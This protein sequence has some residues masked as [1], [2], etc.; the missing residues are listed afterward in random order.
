MENLKEKVERVIGEALPGATTGL[1]DIPL[2]EKLSGFVIWEEF[3]G[4]SQRER[5][6]TLWNV[7]RKRLDAEEQLGLSAIL[8][9]SPAEI[10]SLRDENS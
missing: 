2:S 3:S 6:H 8:T 1:E 5:Q 10:A 4:E 7:L 9:V